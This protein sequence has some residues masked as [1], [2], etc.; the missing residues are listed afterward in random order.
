MNVVLQGCV[1]EKYLK[2]SFN[3]TK[4]ISLSFKKTPRREELREGGRNY[5]KRCREA[6]VERVE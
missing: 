4:M 6:D 5:V 3:A 1:G 2:I